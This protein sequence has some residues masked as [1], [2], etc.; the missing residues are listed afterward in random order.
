VLKSAATAMRHSSE[1]QSSA[2]YDKEKQDR[3][4]GKAVRVCEQYASRF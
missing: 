3:L 2:A 1:M 4:I